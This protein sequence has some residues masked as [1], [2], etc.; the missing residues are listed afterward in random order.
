MAVDPSKVAT[1][2]SITITR[3]ELPEYTYLGRDGESAAK[4]AGVAVSYYALGVF[5]LA[6]GD[7]V[8][9]KSEQPYRD[10]IKSALDGSKPSFEATLNSKL[11]EALSQRGIKTSWISAPP[12]LPDNSGYDLTNTDAT[13]DFVIEL[14]PF[15][16]GFS[17]EKGASHPN[18]DI[19]W[20]LLK[21][22]PSGKLIETNR[23]TVFYDATFNLGNPTSVQIPANNEYA[24]RGHVTDLKAHGEKPAIA[25]RLIAEQVAKITAERALPIAK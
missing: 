20:R 22:Y 15:A 3:L 5:G 14:F 4:H 12:K 17:F 23:G 6:V 10:A 2:K 7:A 25:M 1:I 8:R 9:T 24:F 21:R 13:T 11:E 18:V 19:R 16:A